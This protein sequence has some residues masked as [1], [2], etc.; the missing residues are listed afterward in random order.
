MIEYN[1][2]SYF[3]QRRRY[4]YSTTELDNSGGNIQLFTDIDPALYTINFL[5]I[6]VYNGTDVNMLTLVLDDNNNIS[7]YTSNGIPAG[8]SSF[9]SPITWDPAPA[10]V[11]F[12]S[13]L[14]LP[15]TF[16]FNKAAGGG[17]G[18]FTFLF[19]YDLIPIRLIAP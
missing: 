6:G 19:Y 4:I 16:T 8:R 3:V 7:L 17:S 15:L 18:F 11:E 12:S 9:Q 13:Y 5:G 1:S 14:L 2:G 10:E